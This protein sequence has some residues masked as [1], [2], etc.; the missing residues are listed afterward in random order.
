[1]VVLP[2]FLGC[3]A[4]LIFAILG[5]VLYFKN[6]YKLNLATFYTLIAEIT[7]WDDKHRNVIPCIVMEKSGFK[8]AAPLKTTELR[9]LLRKTARFLF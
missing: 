8:M 7:P 9:F 3:C 2:P 1:M 6:L 5:P 4:Q